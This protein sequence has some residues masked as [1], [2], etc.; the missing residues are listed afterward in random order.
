[1]KLIQIFYLIFLFSVFLNKTLAL[2]K[3]DKV[4]DTLYHANTTPRNI[5]WIDVPQ[6]SGNVNAEF[7]VDLSL[8]VS[9][10]FTSSQKSDF[11]EILMNYD[12]NTKSF[13]CNN[14]V[15]VSLKLRLDSQSNN[16]LLRFMLIDDVNMD[17]AFNGDD[18]VF[19]YDFPLNN[20]NS[21]WI[22]VTM[23]YEK[24]YLWYT[25]ALGF[26]KLSLE[27]IR[28]WRIAIFNE[29]N[30]NQAKNIYFKELKISCLAVPLIAQGNDRVK[31][32]SSFIQLW[33]DAGCSCGEWSLGKWVI[34]IGKM[35]EIGIQRLI[36][37]YS[38]Y[39]THSWYLNSQSGMST[40]DKIILAAEF[41]GNFKIVFG[42]Y[43]DET[44]NWKSKYD[45]NTYNEL[46]LKHK[47]VIDDIYQRFG[48]KLSFDGFYLPQ[49]WNNVE[50]KNDNS[51]KLLAEW[52]KNV[53]NYAK[54]KKSITFIIS[55][56]FRNTVNR[57]TTAL[58]FDK[59]LSIVTNNNNG[60][61]IDEIYIQDSF[62][63][64]EQNSFFD[65]YT[66]FEIINKSTSKYNAK[67]GIT[68]E[69]FNQTTTNGI[70]AAIPASINRIDSQVELANYLTKDLV[71]FEWG[72]MALDNYKLYN[73]YKSFYFN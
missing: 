16:D 68:I 54:S 23:P 66:Y 55:P 73:D 42:L 1:M 27:T 57:E 38:V 3:L 19:A 37:Q 14:P 20:L 33:N 47:M 17:G 10:Q 18:G 2:K 35:L 41:N 21:N 44:W 29:N 32:K 34:E 72:Y 24:F 60:P 13:Q 25:E 51:L 64:A 49:E 28:A 43:F 52:T 6:G 61:F 9:Y 30:N 69:I 70:F 8:H 56:F 7:T 46:Y 48:N 59:Y 58:L 4:V 26:K 63:V 12:K 36:V 5:Y 53:L 62:G 67:L 15:G 65:I 22:E 11:F 40:L 31:M 71:H 39:D 50:W 45:P